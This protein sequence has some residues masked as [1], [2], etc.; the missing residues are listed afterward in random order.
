MDLLE[1]RQIDMAARMTKVRARARPWRSIFAALIAIAGAIAAA[2]WGVTDGYRGLRLPGQHPEKII[3]I[4]GLA[5]FVVFG[6]SAAIGLSGKAR[7][8]FQPLIGQAHAGVV[9]YVLALAGMFTILVFTL[10]I[11]GVSPDKLVVGGAVTGVLLGI[12]AQQSLANL[13]AGLV[14]L[15]ASP[16]RVGDRVRFRAGSLSGEIEGIVT[17]LSLTY[18]RLETDQGRMLLPNAQALAAAVLLIPEQ[19]EAGSPGPA[20]PADYEGAGLPTAGGTTD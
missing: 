17:D 8:A 13:F 5:V 9:R 6:V 20:Q 19:T 2:F 3:W 12:A 18:V 11:V 16:F 7:S 1:R 10:A 15:F 4:S 14:L